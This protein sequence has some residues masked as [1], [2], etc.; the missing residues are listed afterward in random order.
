M[1]AKL[2]DIMSRDVEVVHPDDTL[3]EAAMKMKARD[4]GFLPV[5]DGAKLVGAVS[6]RDITIHA[7]A[8]GK[9][10][11][12]T[13]IK[14]LGKSTVAWCYDDQ[15]P[16]DAA[17]MMKDKQ[18]R[19]VMVIDREMKQLVGVVSVGDLATKDSSKTSGSVMEKTG[20]K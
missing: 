17:K 20:P 19:R 18:V 10:P 6:D 1:S 14:D 7:V 13:K 11:K 3:Q 9:D 8:E 5:C 15:S 12:K 2:R 16:D 4:V